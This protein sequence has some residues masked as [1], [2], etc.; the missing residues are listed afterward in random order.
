METESNRTVASEASKELP[1][2]QAF[3]A[4]VAAGSFTKAAKRTRTDKSLLSRR[5]QALEEHLGVRLLQRTTRKIHVTEA[6][7]ALYTSVVEPLDTI[8][9]ALQRAAEPDELSGRLRVATLPG[10]SRQLVVPAVLEMRRRHPSVSVEV[11]ADETMVDIVAEGVD[12][13]LRAGRLAD[14]SLISR[15]IGSWRYVLVGSPSWVEAHPDVDTPEAIANHWV[16]YP[17]VPSADTW[18]LRRGD[19]TV[20]VRVRPVLTIDEGATM[21]EAVTQGLG[22][23]TFI[24]A[25]V[26]QH[27]ERGE[28]VRVLPDWSVDYELGIYAVYPHRALLPKR[29]SVFIDIV[30]E[31]VAE[32]EPDWRRYSG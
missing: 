11:L 2:L 15:R 29:V 9:A 28:L 1:L 3:V 14:S 30:S 7:T 5:V 8:V 21:I 24:P 17:N 25:Y 20:D 10:F 19:E 22:V 4:V 23:T 32:R 27:L 16:L 13:A 6:G 18:R 12:V 26:Q 31:L